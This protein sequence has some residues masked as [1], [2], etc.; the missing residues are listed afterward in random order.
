MLQPDAGTQPAPQQH[1]R[2]RINCAVRGTQ[3]VSRRSHVEA[4]HLWQHQASCFCCTC[5]Q[6]QTNGA[7][8]SSKSCPR[9]VKVTYAETPC[10]SCAID[11]PPGAA[12][13]VQ[14]RRRHAPHGSAALR[15]WARIGPR[16]RLQPIARALP[17][18]PCESLSLRPSSV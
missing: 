4:S 11:C 9:I 15:A 14:S 17:P 7:A 16:P 13:H 8:Q 12:S 6:A 2:G 3:P 1:A 5:G 10:H 18:V